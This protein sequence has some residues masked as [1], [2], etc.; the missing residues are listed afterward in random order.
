LIYSKYVTLKNYIK[1]PILQNHCKMKNIQSI[2]K[3][4]SYYHQH[5]KTKYNNLR[6]ALGLSFM[7]VFSSGIWFLKPQISDFFSNIDIFRSNQTQTALVPIENK[8]KSVENTPVFLE[9]HIAES[10][11]YKENIK[12]DSPLI[13]QAPDSKMHTTLTLAVKID[14]IETKSGVYIASAVAPKIDTI[15]E[16]KEELP[17]FNAFEQ[18]CF[19]YFPKNNFQS[20]KNCIENQRYSEATKILDKTIENNNNAEQAEFAQ[21]LCLIAQYPKN[22]GNMYQKLDEIIAN[23]N[24]AFF[25]Q[26]GNIKAKLSKIVR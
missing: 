22:K 23:K 19:Q 11:E 15:A 1:L 7:V 17:Q 5:K 21:L 4:K 20:V 10:P 9:A 26:A 18:L 2:K 14:T 6:F 16:K 25:S 13:N 8:P 3:Q 12:I 24:H